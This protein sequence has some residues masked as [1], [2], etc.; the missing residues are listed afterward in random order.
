MIIYHY[1]EATELRDSLLLPLKYTTKSKSKRE[2]EAA[3]IGLKSLIINNC[4]QKRT[5]DLDLNEAHKQ[6]QMNDN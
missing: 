3:Q 1:L 6:R 2:R 4:Q 5:T